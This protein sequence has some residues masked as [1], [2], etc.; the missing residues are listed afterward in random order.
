MLITGIGWRPNHATLAPCNHPDGCA[1]QSALA[2]SRRTTPYL[3]VRHVLGPDGYP[4]SRAALEILSSGAAAEHVRARAATAQHLA[5]ERIPTWL[6]S[7]SGRDRAVPP[8]PPLDAA[9]AQNPATVLQWITDHAHAD[10]RYGF[11]SKLFPHQPER[12]AS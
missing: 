10:Y 8:L 4:A 12:K 5:E 11:S 2:P 7:P 1:T 9:G 3:L 6:W